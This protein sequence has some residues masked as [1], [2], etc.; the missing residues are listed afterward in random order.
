MPIP[1]CQSSA[2]KHTSPSTGHLDVGHD[3]VKSSHLPSCCIG[4]SLGA[5]RMDTMDAMDTID[6]LNPRPV[7]SMDTMD[8]AVH[9]GQDGLRCQ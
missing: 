9:N 8:V 4:C 1:I 7:D 6:R 3:H 5:D 2:A